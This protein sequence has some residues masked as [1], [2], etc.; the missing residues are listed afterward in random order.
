[1]FAGRCRFC[2]Q[3][4]YLPYTRWICAELFRLAGFH[5]IIVFSF[6]RPRV[7]LDQSFLFRQPFQLWDLW[8]RND[9]VLLP[10]L[11]RNGAAPCV[12]PLVALI[13]AAQGSRSWSNTWRVR[14]AGRMLSKQTA[15]APSAKVP[16]CASLKWHSLSGTAGFEASG[17]SRGELAASEVHRTAPAIWRP[18]TWRWNKIRRQWML[19]CGSCR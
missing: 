11:A 8:A 1:M 2:Y 6:V 14:A 9:G 5:P 7:N 10:G 15:A 19:T 17:G 18:S 4:I 3:S 12:G 16:L 13:Q